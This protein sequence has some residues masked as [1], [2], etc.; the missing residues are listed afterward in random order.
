MKNR[1]VCTGRGDCFGKLKSSAESES[2]QKPLGL[3]D[4]RSRREGRGGVWLGGAWGCGSPSTA[5]L[6]PV[7]LFPTQ[8]SRNLPQPLR[9][10]GP[11]PPPPPHAVGN[12]WREPGEGS[13]LE[14]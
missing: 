13:Q 14:H 10:G 4:E 3:E 2:M 5:F 11:A 9:E 7:L 1:K 12:V 6:S 8:Q